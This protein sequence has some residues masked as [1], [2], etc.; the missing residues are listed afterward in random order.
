MSI[1]TAIQTKTLV[2]DRP[3]QFS[4]FVDLTTAPTIALI[5]G[6]DQTFWVMALVAIAAIFSALY[7]WVRDVQEQ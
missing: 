3:G 5:N 2:I 1:L 6:I 4:S 7:L